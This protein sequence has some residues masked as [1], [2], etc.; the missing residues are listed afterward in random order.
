MWVH[1]QHFIICHCSVGQEFGHVSARRFSRRRFHAD[2]WGLRDPPWGL[3]V[4]T[5]FF[6]HLIALS[7]CLY[8]MASGFPEWEL[9]GF[10]RFITGTGT[11][12]FPLQS[13]GKRR[14]QGWLT[15]KGMGNWIHPLMDEAAWAYGEK[16]KWW[17]PTL[18]TVYC[19]FSPISDEEIGTQRDRLTH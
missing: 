8:S 5:W 12:S 4:S 16:R 1:A 3:S 7:E 13:T 18:E 17:Q 2:I 19:H 14:S 9:P 15:F 6:L 11:D 10:L